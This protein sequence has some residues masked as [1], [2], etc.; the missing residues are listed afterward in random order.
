M[1]AKQKNTVKEDGRQTE[2][3]VRGFPAKM[4][5]FRYISVIETEPSNS[6]DITS[7]FFHPTPT[8]YQFKIGA[9]D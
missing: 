7:I 1:T 3:V 4:D 5:G 9:Y 8:S 2:S 6:N